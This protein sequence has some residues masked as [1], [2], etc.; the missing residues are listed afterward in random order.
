[1][2]SI[3]ITRWRMDMTWYA[4]LETL[5]AVRACLCVQEGHREHPQLS[6][7]CVVRPALPILCCGDSDGDPAHPSTWRN[8]IA[9]TKSMSKQVCKPI[10]YKTS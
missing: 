1:M 9:E 2:R 6:N 3:K 7:E 10:P 4:P 5:T 8:S